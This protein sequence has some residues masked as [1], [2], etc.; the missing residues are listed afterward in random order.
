[1]TR[2]IT[3]AILALVFATFAYLQFN[4]PDPLLWVLLYGI[5][6]LV[7]LLQVFDISN[8]RLNGILLLLFVLY[9]LNYLPGFYEWMTQPNKTE[10]F[11]EMVDEKPYIE[12]AREFIG[13]LMSIGVLFCQFRVAKTKPLS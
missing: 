4:D 1:M 13:L 10:L 8:R 7:S 3:S 9:S 11:G 5:V 2:K 6:S 12:E